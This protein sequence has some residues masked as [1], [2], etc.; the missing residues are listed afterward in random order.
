MNVLN[1]YRAYGNAS[2]CD[3]EIICVIDDPKFQ[4]NNVCLVNRI[5]D[6]H[7]IFVGN[8]PSGKQVNVCKLSVS[9][10]L[11]VSQ[12]VR[13]WD[14][15]D[16]QDLSEKIE[17][18]GQTLRQE[19][20]NFRQ[21]EKEILHELEKHRWHP[22]ISSHSFT[23]LLNLAFASLEE[24]KK[25]RSEIEKLVDAGLYFEFNFSI[26]IL[27]SMAKARNAASARTQLREIFLRRQKSLRDQLDQQM[28]G[29]K[30]VIVLCDQVHLQDLSLCKFLKTKKFTVVAHKELNQSFVN[31]QE[32]EI[33]EL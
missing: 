7:L 29:N 22:L 31:L 3:A 21:F 28:L 26:K 12:V 17:S 4:M 24:R 23:V 32:L 14:I 10:G 9:C 19:D 20:V 15:E 11:T 13:G 6:Q 25:K 33:R 18:L 8:V 1:H 16:I 27:L 30:K 2:T 5:W